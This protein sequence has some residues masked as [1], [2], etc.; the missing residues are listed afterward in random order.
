MTETVHRR[1]ARR[2]ETTHRLRR[3]A[4]ELTRDK[5][6]DGWTMDDL[7]A[8]AEV[9]RRTV[10]NY[11]DSKLDVVLGPDHEPPAE[12]LAAFV[13]KRPTGDLV[14][15]MA[16]L[17]VEVIQEKQTELD[18]VM[19]ARAVI[20]TEPHLVALVH[21]RFEAKMT[22]LVDLII[23]REGEDYGRAQAELAVRLIVTVFDTALS[24]ID[25]AE[26]KPIDDHIADA[27]IDARRLFARTT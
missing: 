2:V 11:F 17:A 8:S 15:D 23:Q 25:P 22:D 14:D 1:E 27:V 21:E 4:L 20:L 24:R 10:F 19:L 5:G 9:S 13:A 7:A 3:R 18:L 12:A 16:A 26:P 6:F